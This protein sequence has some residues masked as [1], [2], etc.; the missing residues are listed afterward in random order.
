MPATQW[1][2]LGPYELGWT[3]DLEP[4]KHLHIAIRMRSLA[5]DGDSVHTSENDW[6]RLDIIP[7][8]AIP[9]RRI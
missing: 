3:E 8:T 9:P 1:G 2:H 5:Y 7:A 6:R 4:T